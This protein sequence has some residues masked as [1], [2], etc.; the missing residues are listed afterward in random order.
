MYLLVCLSSFFP[1]VARYDTMATVEHPTPSEIDRLCT[2]YNTD[3]IYHYSSNV[4][5]DSMRCCTQHT[6]AKCVWAFVCISA[7][8]LIAQF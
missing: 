6:N 4:M 8:R 5:R 2:T 3:S 1:T 7:T